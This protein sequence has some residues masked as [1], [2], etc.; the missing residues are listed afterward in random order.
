MNQLI[1]S[2]L[3][4]LL[5]ANI[6]FGEAIPQ[7]MH[8][9]FFKSDLITEIKIISHTD[10]Y[11]TIRIREVFR[12][13][14]FGLKKDDYIR[15][16]KDFNRRS[17]SE[18]I[19]RNSIMNNES[20]IAFLVKTSNGWTMRRFFLSDEGN[21]TTTLYLAGCT[22]TGSIAEL[23]KQIIEYFKEFSLDGM[24]N[25][26]GLKQANE[27]ISTEHSELVLLQ[28]YKL[29][30]FSFDETILSHLNCFSIGENTEE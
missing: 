28:Y 20:G 18:V 11:Y 17:S 25:L 16:K 4:I 7:K 19:T 5:N 12:D 22:V 2:V 3:L 23:K 27:I 29:D 6:V 10:S 14:R 21:E 8:V 30:P 26:V 1:L 9:L 15:I 13:N 24:G